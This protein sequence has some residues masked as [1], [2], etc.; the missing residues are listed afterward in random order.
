MK[1]YEVVRIAN[2]EKLIYPVAEDKYVCNVVCVNIF[3]QH[4]RKDFLS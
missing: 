3:V 1:R 4:C 2:L